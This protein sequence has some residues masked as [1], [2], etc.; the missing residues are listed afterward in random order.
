MNR[1]NVRPNVQ[2][3][4]A[5]LSIMNDIPYHNGTYQFITT[6]LSEFKRIGIYPCLTSYYYIAH[7]LRKAPGN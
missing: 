5:C 7:M 6:V 4:N 1:K 2:T 3:L